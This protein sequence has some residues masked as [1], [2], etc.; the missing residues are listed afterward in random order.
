MDFMAHRELLPNKHTIAI[1]WLLLC[2]CTAK[3]KHYNAATTP[4]Q[5]NN[6]IVYLNQKPLTGHVYLLNTHQKDTLFSKNYRQGKQNGLNE[7]WYSNGQ[8]NEIRYFDKGRKTGEHQGFWG[9]GNKRFLFH[10]KNDVYEGTQSKWFENGQLYQLKNYKNGQEEGEQKEWN[11]TGK[12][13]INYET[14]NGRQYGNIGKK[15]CA[16]IWRQDVYIK[17]DK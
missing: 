14:H 5:T 1:A 16:S 17:P 2:S 6:G 10:F 4:L 11:N 8:L 15:N 9:N 12:L 3:T 13:V 7:T